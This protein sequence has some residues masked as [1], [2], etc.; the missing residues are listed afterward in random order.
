MHCGHVTIAFLWQLANLFKIYNNAVTVLTAR[1]N[2]CPPLT[3]AR[4]VVLTV[5]RKIVRPYVVKEVAYSNSA[6]LLANTTFIIGAFRPWRFVAAF[7]YWNR[8]VRFYAKNTSP[9]V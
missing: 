6:H 5:A 8:E 1:V 2:I 7:V 3:I 4:R 9:L